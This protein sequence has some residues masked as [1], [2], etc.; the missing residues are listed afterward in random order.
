MSIK[1]SVQVNF[2]S[3]EKFQKMG[4][5]I[6]DALIDSGAEMVAKAQNQAP[7]RSGNLKRSISFEAL[8]EPAILVKA[9]APYAAFVELGTGR[10]GA[11][12]PHPWAKDVGWRYG[13]KKGMAGKFFLYQG[14]MEGAKKLA[15]RIKNRL[16]ND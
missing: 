4:N 2:N 12:S 5:K 11:S 13:P 9:G 7:I 10:A 8:E 15:E 3:K 1:V 6:R 14:I 16:K